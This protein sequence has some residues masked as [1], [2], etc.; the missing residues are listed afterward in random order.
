MKLTPNGTFSLG[1]WGGGIKPHIWTS[2]NTCKLDIAE[3]PHSNKEWLA[4]A[5]P[6]SSWKGQWLCCKPAWG[7]QMV[8]DVSMCHTHTNL[9]LRYRL[10]KTAT[11][12]NHPRRGLLPWT[13]PSKDSHIRLKHL[14][15][16]WRPSRRTVTEIPGHVTTPE[17]PHR[18]CVIMSGDLHCVPDDRIEAPSWI[19]IGLL[20]GST[21]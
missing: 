15:V 5:S 6:W 13:T 3:T 8:P 1:D 18:P 14:W 16:Q 17:Y 19:G 4:R 12:W 11:T 10:Q 9:W 7:L 20:Q 2:V 21:G